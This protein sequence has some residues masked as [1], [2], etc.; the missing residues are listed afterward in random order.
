MDMPLQHASRDVLSRMKRGSSGD[1]FLKFLDRV[2]S[3]IPGISLRTSFIVGF[4]GETE[5]DFEELCD[6]V[7][8]AK[9]DWLGVFEYSDV[10]TAASFALGDKLEPEVITARRNGLM[11]IQKRISQH[12]LRARVGTVLLA[13]VEGPSKENELVWEAR[14]EGMAPEIDGKLILTDIETEAGETAKCGDIVRVEI[15]KASAY[16]LIGH[17]VEICET[18]SRAESTVSRRS[19]TSMESSFPAPSPV[20]RIATGAPLRILS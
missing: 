9:F 17:V 7:S 5:A 6:F 18:N 3:T 11:A 20:Q 8:A 12:K 2:R 16:D 1:A 14:L 15:S 19:A 10:D 4:P 13:L